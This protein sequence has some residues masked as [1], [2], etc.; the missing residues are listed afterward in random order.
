MKVIPL[1]QITIAENRQRKSFEVKSLVELGESIVRNGLFHPVVLRETEGKF[2]LVSGE[3]RLRAVKDLH[4][5]CAGYSHDNE[6]VPPGTI[7]YVTLGELDDL[8]REEAEWEENIRREN[9]TWQELALATARLSQLRKNQAIAQGRPQPTVADIALEIRGSSEGS[10]QEDTRR[11]ILVAAHLSDPEV[12][13]AK[14]ADEGFKILRRKEDTAKRVQL[15]IEVGRTYSA[16]TAHRI[17]NQD[18]LSWMKF[19]L[20]ETFDVVLTDPP[21]GIDADKFADSGGVGGIKGAHA[22]ADTYENWK[23]IIKVLA[24]ES[25]RV[26]K[27]M[28]HIY[29]FCD[30]DRFHEL[31]QCMQEAGWWVFRT[32][33][34][35]HKPNAARAPWPEHGPQRQYDFILYAV[36]GKRQVTRLYPDVLIY[37]PDPQLDHHAQK[38]VALYEDLLRRSVQAGDS[39]LDPFAGSG[40][41]LPAAFNLKC[42]ATALEIDPAAYAICVKRLQA[43]KDQPELEGLV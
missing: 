43:L 23:N 40:P 5:L 1:D 18:S 12:A 39:V 4:E 10:N 17:L 34:I 25:F 19:A 35:F 22:Y 27:P 14:S 28:A 36:K 20:P 7:P 24:P 32:P 41:I 16:E 2:F 30:V 9:L 21:Y 37:R 31:R 33:L 13:A 6:P 11:K 42:K 38:P 15:A 3:R 26:A 8:A 29:I